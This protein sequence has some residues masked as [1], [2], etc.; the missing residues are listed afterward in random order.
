[1]SRGRHVG[2]NWT[3]G[4]SNQNLPG[5]LRR[6][7]PGARGIRDRQLGRGRATRR[8]LPSCRRS[9]RRRL[10]LSGGASYGGRAIS[11]HRQSAGR[12]EASSTRRPTGS[13]SRRSSRRPP[14]R[15]PS[16]T[17]RSRRSSA[18]RRASGRAQAEPHP[19]AR[20]ELP[21][22]RRVPLD[23]LEQVGRRATARRWHAAGVEARETDG[24]GRL[25]RRGGRHVGRQRVPSD[26]AQR[27]GQ[28]SGRTRASSCAG[29]TRA[30]GTR[31]TRGAVFI[32]GLGQR[33]D[34]RQRLPDEPSELAGRPRLLDG[35]ERI[36]QRL[37]AGGVRRLPPVRRAGR[38]D[39]APARLPQRLPPARA[40]RS[41][42]PARRRS[43]SPAASCRPRSARSPTPRGSTSRATA[44]R[45]SRSTRCRRSSR[46]RSTH[47]ARSA[48]RSASRRITGASRGSRGTAA[49]CPRATSTAQTGQILDRL[50]AAIRDSG[51][52]RPERSRERRLRTA[53]TERLLRRRLH[54]R[55]VQRVVE[56]APH[57]ARS[58]CSRSRRRRRRSSPAS[59]RR[60]SPSGC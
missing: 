21:R 39:H 52:G 57:V 31:P 16:T 24:A 14:P 55:A 1:M 44:G 8:R 40:R 13:G 43:S 29:C 26:G 27:T 45:W 3:T 20:P 18:T 9:S 23:D 36:R 49:A 28:R 6:R 10:K 11:A 12:C 47:S 32:V 41:P 2:Y 53:G 25:R 35:H 19:R 42:A 58:P 48:S 60:R 56:G 37:V 4:G 38:S 15:A 59:R 51:P 30:T 33:D 5:H 22:A 7:R 46:R 54:G 17:S 50:G 34:E